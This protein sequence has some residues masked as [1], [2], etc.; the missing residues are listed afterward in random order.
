MFCNVSLLAISNQRTLYLIFFLAPLLPLVFSNLDPLLDAISNADVEKVRS[1]LELKNNDV[2]SSH[3]GIY[4][5]RK[6]KTFG[7]IALQFCAYDPNTSG[8]KSVDEKCFQI[9]KIMHSAGTNISHVDD[10]GWN[11]IAMGAVKGLSKFCEYFIDN[12]VYIDQLDKYGRSP[13]MKATFHG[14]LNTVKMLVGKGANVSLVDNEKW[15]LLHFATR[16]AVS[17]DRFLPTLKFII[18]LFSNN[19]HT[20]YIID[21]RDSYQRTSLMYAVTANNIK[22]IQILL[23][24]GADTRED[25]NGITIPFTTNNLE[26]REM[27][28]KNSIRR[29]E[30]DHA[31]WLESED[32]EY[33]L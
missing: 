20:K 31:R 30:Q 22:V 1:L 9:A 10:E 14:H 27:L 26:L 6:V 25:E 19:I 28:L 29:I 24:H 18:E 17:D 15:T 16:Q 21:S 2:I 8:E 23:D 5:N 32:S 3:P 12:G 11:L 7:R 4:V 13:L 33:D